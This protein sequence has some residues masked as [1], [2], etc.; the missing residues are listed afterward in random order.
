MAEIDEA[1]ELSEY[2][3]TWPR[4]FAEEQGRICQALDIPRE[5]LEHTGSTVVPG[6]VAKPIVDLM[7]G[8]RHFPP[9]G[10]FL[11]R[12]EL[13]GWEALG[14]AGVPGRLYFRMRAA[15]Q[16]NLHVVLKSG[17]QI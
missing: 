10:E 16:A 14:E 8:V 1:I 13:L 4:A 2:Q 6:L 12:I 7:L 5:D 9:D 17:T 15:R 11:K 3:A